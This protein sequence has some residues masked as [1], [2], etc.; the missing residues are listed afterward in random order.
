[1]VTCTIN[2][3]AD[4]T[5]RSNGEADLELR[6]IRVDDD[7]PSDQFRITGGCEEKTLAPG[8]YCTLAFQWTPE[9]GSRQATAQLI[10]NQNLPGPTQTVLTLR[11]PAETLAIS[12]VVCRWTAR[13]PAELAVTVIVERAGSDAVD[14]QVTHTVPGAPPAAPETVRV[15][16]HHDRATAS[17]TVAAPTTSGQSVIVE[18]DPG[19]QVMETEETDNQ[20]TLA[21]NPLPP[22]SRSSVAQQC[23]RA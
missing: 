20:Q 19:R 21:V 3:C 4:V 17:F 8:E 2:Q 18:V 12:A 11:G 23:P 16:P 13:D 22:K 7:L 10:I 6:E 9:P 14:V 5:I 15:Q 1:V